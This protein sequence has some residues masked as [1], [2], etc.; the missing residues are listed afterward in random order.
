MEVPST[1][2]LIKSTVIAAVVAGVLLVTVVMPS[3]YGI[4]PTGIGN[5]LGLKRMGEIKVS[6]AEEAAL[7]AAQDISKTKAVEQIDNASSIPTNTNAMLTQN[8]EKSFTLS[9]DEGTEIKL[10]MVR[11]AKVN[12][13]WETDGGKANFDVHADSTALNIDYHPYYKGSDT[14]KEGVLTA[15]FNGSHGWFWRNRTKAP[16]TIILKT[17]GEYTDIK[18]Y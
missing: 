1:S 17:N 5:A 8:H 6:L 9:P 12:Y 15:A 14:K 3:E 4:D 18:R 11:G 7:D 2:K 10:I 13:V 16:M